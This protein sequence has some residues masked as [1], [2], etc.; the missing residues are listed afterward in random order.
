[1]VTVKCNVIAYLDKVLELN[2]PQGAVTIQL[3]QAIAVSNSYNFDMFTAAILIGCIIAV[4]LFTLWARSWSEIP[5]PDPVDAWEP[6]E[7]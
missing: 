7:D 5:A 3:D 4:I 6:E 1:M 2:C